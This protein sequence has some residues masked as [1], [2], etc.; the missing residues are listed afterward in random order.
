MTRFGLAAVFCAFVLGSMPAGAQETPTP[1]PA[2]PNT[3]AYNDPAMSFTAAPG[4]RYLGGRPYDPLSSEPTVVAAF[5]SNP[6]EQD[7]HLVQIQIEFCEGCRLSGYE[8]LATDE[9]RGHLNNALVSKKQQTT[10]SNGMPA[11]W[12]EISIG[13]GFQEMKRWQYEWVDGQRGVILSDSGRYGGITEEQA[14]AELANV[15]AVDY[16]RNRI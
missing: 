9:L 1:A 2:N 14:K 10:L 11:L 13:E 8:T 4:F 6:G 3:T 12:E 7:A 16:P 5:V 15:S